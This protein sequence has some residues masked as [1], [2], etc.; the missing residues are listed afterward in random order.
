MSF[1]TNF[2]NFVFDDVCRKCI[3]TSVFGEV[4]NTFGRAEST[5]FSQVG[6][7]GGR[8][9]CLVLIPTH[10]V[11][12]VAKPYLYAIEAT[13]ESVGLI[14][15]LIAK[16]TLYI[17]K[18]LTGSGSASLD[19]ESIQ[20][21]LK[22]SLN[23]LACVII[24]P[25][26]QVAQVIKVV[27]GII[28]PG[29]YFKT[30][31]ENSL[32]NSNDNDLVDYL[33]GLTFNGTAYITCNSEDIKNKPVAILEQFADVIR[34]FGNNLGSIYVTFTDEN[35]NDA[36]EKVW[37]GQVATDS[38]G[39]RREFVAK[40][41]QA[42]CQ[43]KPENQ[44][45]NPTLQLSIQPIQ[46]VNDGNEKILD[47]LGVVLGWLLAQNRRGKDR[48]A[49]PIGCGSLAPIILKGAFAFTADDLTE[50][51]GNLTFEQKKEAWL[52]IYGD[53]PQSPV[54]YFELADK[55]MRLNDN[56]E[57]DLE[58][59]EEV[60][61]AFDTLYISELIDDE[62]SIFR[63]NPDGT[64]IL[65]EDEIREKFN[66]HLAEIKKTLREDLEERLNAVET[67]FLLAKGM[68]KIGGGIC[69]DKWRDTGA[70]V[71]QKTLEGIFSKEEVMRRLEFINIPKR[72]VTT[73]RKWVQGLNTDQLKCFLVFMRGSTSLLGD[74]RLT[75]QGINRVSPVI[76][77]HTCFSR[78]DVAVHNDCPFKNIISML[79]HEIAAI[80]NGNIDYVER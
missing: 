32:N 53:D 66:T 41:F 30:A 21:T 67:F 34:Y 75:F 27:A 51:F 48:F 1:R 49:L 47:D 78:V 74:V 59:T 9:A 7:F 63:R 29:F 56:D 65:R 35:I 52:N 50:E 79:N 60:T 55:L 4:K 22:T 18:K 45:D 37:K 64:F 46:Q 20:K 38:G 15:L 24:S 17:K 80:A 14:F 58:F 5:P 28:Y 77:S 44:P 73:L 12:I 26:G 69:W 11:S 71:N 36:G 25:A 19:N 6:S 31:S 3:A 23:M 39:P 70:E 10:I 8:V 33:D 13:I 62:R 2:T 76:F 16:P 72:Y 43:I 54:I 57:A 68:N 61:N 42:L 40:L